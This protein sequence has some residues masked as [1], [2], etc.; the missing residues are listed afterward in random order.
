MIETRDGL[1]GGAVLLAVCG[2]VA[3]YQLAPTW[4]HG[5]LVAL[6]VVFVVGAL[7][8][9]WRQRARLTPRL[10]SS[11]LAVGGLVLLTVAVLLVAGAWAVERGWLPALGV[12][13]RFLTIGALGAGGA[14]A[15]WVIA[16]GRSSSDATVSPDVGAIEPA[17]PLSAAWSASPDWDVVVREISES[18]HGQHAKQLVVLRRIHEILEAPGHDDSVRVANAL[19]AVRQEVARLQTDAHAAE[20]ESME[21]D[22]L[23]QLA[24]LLEWGAQK[25]PELAELDVADV[26]MGKVIADI[27]TRCTRV[28]HVFLDH[29]E[30][31]PIHPID[32]DTANQK[33]EERAAAA[34]DA[35]PLLRANGMRLSEQL[36]AAHDELAAFRSV[37]GFQVV[38]L[39]EGQGY[40]T[41]EGNGRREALQRAFGASD[42]VMIEVRLFRFG[43]EATRRKIVRRVQRVRSWKDVQ[44]EHPSA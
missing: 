34:R 22:A 41:F 44:H 8:T 40:V 2:L 21:R 36:I 15:A 30:L 5:E 24:N 14:V 25:L 27:R 11:G 13:G 31:L 6:A 3:C 7:L 39:G 16:R 1:A 38:S 35:L 12:A 4:L 10:V 20:A 33:C 23:S 37:N 18:D 17:P 19:R 29:R 9:G 28:E 42:P 32:R 43:D 26:L